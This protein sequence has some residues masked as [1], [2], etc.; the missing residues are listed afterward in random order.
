MRT[1]IQRHYPRGE[2]LIAVSDSLAELAGRQAGVLT[3]N[4]LAGTGMTVAQLKAAVAARR[5]QTFGRTVVVLHNGPLSPIQ[6]EWVAV[7]LPAK[8]AAL[9]GLSA[10]AAAGLRGFE[11]EQVHVVVPHDTH[12]GVPAWV[13]LHES[14]RFAEIDIAEGSAPP[15]TGTARALIDAATWSARPRRACAILCAGVQQRLTTAA[16]LEAELAA[17]GSVRHV[18]I[19]RTILGDIGGGGHTLAEIDLA[20]LA[21]KAG[22][23]APRRQR[24]R[25]EHDGKVRWLDVEFDLPD[26]TVLVVEIDGR[27]HLEVETWLDDSDRQN[28]VVIDGRTVLRFPSITV[29]LSG[30]RVIDQLARMRRAHTFS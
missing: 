1:D 17:A 22:L 18:G 25:R 2:R 3:R 11:P 24:F 8:P 26:G 30:P 21:R 27:G 16:R 5:W 23:S 10:A 20:P 19:M 9:A 15:R 28:E 29:R 6:R 13:K 14:R 7:L 4:Q 12:T